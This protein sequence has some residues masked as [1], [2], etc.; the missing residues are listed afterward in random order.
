M[1]VKE[2]IKVGLD[3][4]FEIPKDVDLILW[5]DDYIPAEFVAMALN[6]AGIEIQKAIEIMVKA[7]ESGKALIGRYSYNVA[8]KVKDNILNFMKSCGY[9]SLKITMEE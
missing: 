6:S 9:I 2:I 4:D 5:N 8:S 1:S 3:F 7:H